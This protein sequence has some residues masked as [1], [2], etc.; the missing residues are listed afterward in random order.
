MSINIWCLA[1]TCTATTAMHSSNTMDFIMF[2][3]FNANRG[4]YTVAA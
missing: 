4:N 1:P 2:T 3:Y